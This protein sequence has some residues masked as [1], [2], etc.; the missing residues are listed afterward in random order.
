[1][2]HRAVNWA[3]AQ[4]RGLDIRTKAVLAALADWA[5]GEGFCY[6]GQQ[7]IARKVSSSERTVRR[8]LDELELLGYIYR[9]RRSDPSGRRMTDGYQLATPPLPANGDTPT[10]GQTEGDNRPTV[11][12]TEN[13]QKN[14]QIEN[15]SAKAKKQ[16]VPLPEDWKP[17]EEHK[18]MATARGLDVEELALAFRFHAEAND[19]R[20]VVWN[21]AFSQW[22][23]N[24]RPNRAYVPTTRTGSAVPAAPKYPD[25]P[26]IDDD[27]QPYFPPPL[28]N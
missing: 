21:S 1:M 15:K 6:P 3:Y 28:E 8:L 2:S 19:R 27:W 5:D 9:A 18:A 25:A 7:S 22:I 13:H 16:P 11:A 17:T 23:M 12:A 24:A 14:H 26:P 4:E 10:T 20:Q